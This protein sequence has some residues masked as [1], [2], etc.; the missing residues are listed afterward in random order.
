[1]SW[2]RFVDLHLAHDIEEATPLWQGLS[3]GGTVIESL[4]PADPRIQ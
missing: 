1:M 3:D 2:H 4:A